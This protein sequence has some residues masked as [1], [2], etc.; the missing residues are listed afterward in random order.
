MSICWLSTSAASRKRQ[1]ILIQVDQIITGPAPKRSVKA[2][3][4]IMNTALGIQVTARTVPMANESPVS[5]RT[6]Q[7]KAIMVSVE[8]VIEMTDPNQSRR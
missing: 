1:I 6:S 7:G 4:K 3:L 2:P 8:P 5:F